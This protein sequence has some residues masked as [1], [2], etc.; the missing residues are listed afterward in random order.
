MTT[1]ILTTLL[2]NDGDSNILAEMYSESVSTD[3]HHPVE[4][5]SGISNEPM[6]TDGGLSLLNHNQVRELENVVSDIMNHDISPDVLAESQELVSLEA[7]RTA[8]LWL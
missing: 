1:K 5:L 6:N 7:S 2:P 8:K 3:G 4:Q